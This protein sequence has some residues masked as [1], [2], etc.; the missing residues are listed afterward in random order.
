VSLLAQDATV[1]GVVSDSAGAVVPGVKITIRSVDANLA[2]TALT[3]PSGDFTIPSLS[4]GRCDLSAELAGFRQHRQTG[5]VLEVGQTLRDDIQ[6]AVGQLTESVQ[7]AA[8]VAARKT[9][10]YSNL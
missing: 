9:E 6:L 8:E 10:K 3:G 5:L 7:V 4:P 2:R 1:T